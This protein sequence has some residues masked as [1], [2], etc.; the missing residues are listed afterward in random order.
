MKIRF[1]IFISSK[2]CVNIIRVF[3]SLLSYFFP[4]S[5]KNSL[6]YNDILRT[7]LP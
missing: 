3:I 6:T 2:A 5:S 1:L 7:L 4:K